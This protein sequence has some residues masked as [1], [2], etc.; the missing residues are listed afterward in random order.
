MTD[1][2]IKNPLWDSELDIEI[3]LGNSRSVLS[4]LQQVGNLPI[5]FNRKS[6]L[7]Y[8][9]RNKMFLCF[10]KKRFLHFGFICYTMGSGFMRSGE[11]RII[12]V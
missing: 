3:C 11:C 8:T 9:G 4:E 12:I 5:L 7:H 1:K 6:L 2:R 10:F